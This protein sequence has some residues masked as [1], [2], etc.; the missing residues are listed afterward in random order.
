VRLAP[1]NS[2]NH[3]F[4]AETMYRLHYPSLAQQ[5]LEQVFKSTQHAI[6]L[7]DL[8]EDRQE[9]LRLLVEMKYDRPAIY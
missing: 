3:L 9:A 2:T 6:K 4:L 8:E 7:Q 5:Q 1:D